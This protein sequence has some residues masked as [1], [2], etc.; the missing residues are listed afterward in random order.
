MNRI[1]LK[2]LTAVV[3]CLVMVLAVFA[4]TSCGDKPSDETTKAPETTLSP[5][6]TAPDTP[7]ET[8][9]QPTYETTRAPYGGPED[10]CGPHDTTGAE[11]PVATPEETVES[12]PA[13][14]PAE[15]DPMPDLFSEINIT[16]NLDGGIDGGNPTVHISESDLKIIMPIRPGYDFLGWTGAGVDTPTVDF[17]IP[18]G[19][20]DDVVLTAHWA[21]NGEF[22]F[23]LDDTTEDIFGKIFFGKTN[24]AFIINGEDTFE[25]RNNLDGLKDEEDNIIKEKMPSINA[26]TEILMRKLRDYFTAKGQ[27]LPVVRDEDLAE[28]AAYDFLFYFGISDCE[29]PEE[30]VATLNYTQYGIAVNENSLCFISWTEPA[31]AAAGEILY[32]IIEHV[33]KG[34]SFADFAGA[35]YVSAVEGTVGEDVPALEGLDGGTDVGEGAYQLYSLDSTKEIYDEYLAKLEAAGYKLH[36]TNV[37]NKTYTATYYN[38]DTV[39]NVMFAG[40]D[41]EGTLGV[42]TDRSLRV[43]VDPMAITALPSTEKPALPEAPV[44]VSSITQLSPTNLCMIIQLSNGHFVI[45]DS[46][47]N[48]CQGDISKFLRSKAPDKNNV[49]VEAWIFSHF[50]QD[51]IGG[52]IDY[53]GV[54]SLNRYITVNNVIYNFPSYRNYM[55]AEESTRDMAN[56]KFWYEE[57]IPAL[58]EKGTNIYQARTGQKYYFGNSEI[59]VL[60]TFEDIAPFNIY[61]DSTN[62]TSIGI[63]I[64]IEGQK[65]MLVG[66]ASEEEFRV[67]AAR[68]G[69]YLKG[70]FVQLAH[71]GTGNGTG[72]HDYYKLVNAPVVFHPNPDD[73]YPLWRGE[74]EI[75]AM[76]NADLVIRT[77]NYGTATLTMPFTVGE[78]IEAERTPVIEPYTKEYNELHKEQE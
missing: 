48:G 35:R 21:E 54:S 16:Y 46:G 28:D 75:W 29:I 56:L 68:Y 9:R 47:N 4:Q 45:L 70:D 8:T 30:F 7:V 74:N 41:P 62:R 44:T 22:E 1:Y 27:T 40:G 37:M 26:S 76:E 13:E 14:T 33:V 6:T 49:V 51:H 20:S 10:T 5:E 73:G 66:D 53:M 69:E 78:K 64:T 11:T 12:T 57:R 55:T 72:P 67:A 31:T 42:D 23:K 50:H 17:T 61:T 25:M 63:S 19:A 43:V 39:V 3:L 59:E 60:W 24:A 65:I 71:H 34:G 38:D 58:R 36:V 52:F 32:E 15:T 18:A 2:K 77:G